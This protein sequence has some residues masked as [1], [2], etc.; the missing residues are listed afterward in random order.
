VKDKKIFFLSFFH[1][2]EGKPANHYVTSH[3]QV[4]ENE[5]FFARFGQYEIASP[6]ISI[7]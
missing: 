2:R 4:Q 7:Y 3:M 6:K 5:Q 1:P